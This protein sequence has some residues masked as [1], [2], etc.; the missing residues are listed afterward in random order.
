[1][2]RDGK[3]MDS[4]FLVVWIVVIRDDQLLFKAIPA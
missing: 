3:T 1:M 2:C 4:L